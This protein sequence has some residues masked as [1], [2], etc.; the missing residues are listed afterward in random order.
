MPVALDSSL[1]DCLVRAEGYAERMRVRW[2]PGDRFRMFFGGK[3]SS[4]THKKVKTGG[5]RVCVGVCVGGVG[6]GAGD[7][8]EV[9]AV[10]WMHGKVEAGGRPGWV[11]WAGGGRG[12][13]GGGG[14]WGALRGCLGSD[15]N[16]PQ[17]A[18][19]GAP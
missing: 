17:V 12:G 14:Q 19:V 11:A 9:G 10:W 2:Q 6:G 15:E 16:C 1:P 8:G 3:I 13:G 7:G 5:Q 18:G 4:K